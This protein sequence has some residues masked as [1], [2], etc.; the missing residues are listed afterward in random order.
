MV[1]ASRVTSPGSGASRDDCNRTPSQSN[2]ASVRAART[3]GDLVERGHRDDDTPPGP[4]GTD[5]DDVGQFASATTDEH[6]VGII[7]KLPERVGRTA[8]HDLDVD[9]VRVGVGTDPLDPV[10]GLLDR[11]DGRAEPRALHGH[12]PG[13]RTD[14]PDEVT[15]PRP[16][17]GER[18]GP[19]LEFGDHGV[20]VGEL[21]LFQGP[22]RGG[23]GRPGDGAHGTESPPL[24]KTEDDTHG[25]TPVPG[26]GFGRADPLDT[27]VAGTERGGNEEFAS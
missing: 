14:V 22:L 9:I 7:G 11:D 15:E 1:A 21:A 26:G 20:A 12:G 8:V 5:G 4:A 2:P 17:P 24:V 6:G 3:A 19:H 16:E 10:G 25:R 27:F 23:W 13:P 18:E